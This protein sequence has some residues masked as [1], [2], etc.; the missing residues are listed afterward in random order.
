M[1]NE[2]NTLAQFQAEVLRVISEQMHILVKMEVLHT[3]AQ[4]KNLPEGAVEWLADQQ[5]K[6]IAQMTEDETRVYELTLAGKM[7]KIVDNLDRQILNSE[8]PSLFW[9]RLRNSEKK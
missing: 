9:K 8:D 4:M 3:F 6:V 1:D 5:E 2:E 7:E